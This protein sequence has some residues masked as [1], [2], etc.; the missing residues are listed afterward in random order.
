MELTAIVDHGDAH[1]ITPLVLSVDDPLA[2]A[3]D[4]HVHQLA[5]VVVRPFCPNFITRVEESCLG[6]AYG[7]NAGGERSRDQSEK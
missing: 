2:L 3:D 7:T 5:L 4:E 1:D 6:G